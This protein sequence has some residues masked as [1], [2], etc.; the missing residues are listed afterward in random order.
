MVRGSFSKFTELLLPLFLC[1][2]EK[3]GEACSEIFWIHASAHFFCFSCLYIVSILFNADPNLSSFPPLGSLSY[4]GGLVGQFLDCVGARPRLLF[5]ASHLELCAHLLLPQAK[6]LWSQLLFFSWPTTLSSWYLWVTWGVSCPWVYLTSHCSSLLSST[7]IDTPQGIWLCVV[8]PC[9]IV[10]W[11]KGPRL[12][13]EYQQS[14]F[15][16][17]YIRGVGE[18]RERDLAEI[19]RNSKTLLPLPSSFQIHPL[20]GFRFI[21][22]SAVHTA[23]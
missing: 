8:L 5:S 17:F 19:Q 11:G 22:V 4:N 16:L 3:K 18:E 9:L 7:D 1:S 20:W 23:L 2:V 15:E 12:H 13:P 21:S 14:W 6:P 10:F